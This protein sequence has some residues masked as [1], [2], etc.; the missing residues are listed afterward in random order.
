VERIEKNAGDEESGEREKEV[1][2]DPEGLAYTGRDGEQAGRG[3]VVGGE[4]MTDQYQRDG[5][6]AHSIERQKMGK[7]TGV[8]PGRFRAWRGERRSAGKLSGKSLFEK[9][10]G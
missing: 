3:H 8:V 6:A 5:Q 2:T 1:D 7:A 10:V 9:V 4:K